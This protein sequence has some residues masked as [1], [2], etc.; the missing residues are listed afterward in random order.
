VTRATIGVSSLLA[1]V[2]IT[3]AGV[4]IG[5]EWGYLRLLAV[6]SAGLLFLVVASTFRP[7]EKVNFGLFKYASVYMLSTMVLLSL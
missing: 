6:L 4:L 1:A 3:A 5:L 2:S 7:S